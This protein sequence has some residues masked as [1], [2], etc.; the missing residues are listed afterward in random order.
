M[1]GEMVVA[2]PHRRRLSAGR[3]EARTVRTLDR[4]AIERVRE[5]LAHPDAWGTAAS[6][7]RYTSLAVARQL[8]ETAENE[9]PLRAL[10]LL[11]LALEIATVV[12]A[13]LTADAP[14][15]SLGWQLFVA[16]RCARV[17]RLLDTADRPS[18]VRELRRAARLL[19]PELGYGRALFCR[20]LARLRRE[21][22]RWEEALALAARAATLL[23][24]YGSTLETGRAQID[25]GWALLDAGEPSEALP[26]FEAALPLVER[27]QAWAVSGHLGLAVALAGS[28]DLK[29]ARRLLTAADRLTA[30]VP[31]AAE[32]LRLRWRGAQMARRCGLTGNALRRLRRVV[33]ALLAEGQDRDAATALLELLALCLQRRSQQA[34]EMTTIQAA[35]DGLLESSQLHRRARA[36]IALVRY[37][38]AD[39][40]KRCAGEVVSTASRY[41]LAS[42]YRPHLPFRPT[43]THPLVH[44]AWDEIDPSVRAGICVE[45]GAE[46]ETGHCTGK[47]LDCALRDYISW[48]FEVLRRVRL[49]F[50][51]SDRGEAP[52][53]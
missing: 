10:H 21:Q 19:A 24:H 4:D 33:P 3:Q 20:A 38:L 22:R 51:A 32:R 48:R 31:Q 23:D 12:T 47:E 39:P 5:L 25:Q 29:R 36:V 2:G 6:E 52:G 16:V 8:V 49:E 27:E 26:V 42:R 17:H 35:I 28:G 43:R 13:N 46:K 53:A 9:E 14:E 11:D 45:V 34:V 50:P 18:A 1:T 30:G 37:V 44:L 15:A 40:V 41:L 7:P